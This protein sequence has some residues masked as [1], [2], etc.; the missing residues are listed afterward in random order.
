MPD[1]SRIESSTPKAV[2]SV[3]LRWG[4]V[5]VGNIAGRFAQGLNFVPNTTLTGVWAR[6]ESESARF[7]AQYST[8]AFATFEEMVNSIDA[9]Y[10]ATLQDS[11]ADYAL[12]AFAAKC[13]VL[14][15]KPAA[16]SAKALKKIQDAAIEANVL[17]ME[18]MKPPFFPLFQRLTQQLNDEPIGDIKFVRAGS[19]IPDAPENHP[20]FKLELG[21]GSLL[22]IGI[23]E[24][25]LAIYFLGKPLKVQTLG[26]VGESGV[27]IFASLNV[28][29][30]KGISQ[31]FSGL[32]VDGKGDAVI[33]GTK[34]S[35]TIHENWWNPSRATVHYV[36][37][38]VVELDVPFEG[39]GLNYETDHF[40]ELLRQ[41]A[42]ES[43]IISHALSQQMISILD[44]AREAL[45]VVYPC[46]IDHT[47][48]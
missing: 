26:R 13:A 1:N 25:F 15:E 46:A 20:S 4:I 2:P 31:L 28:L 33:A 3:P 22:N 21:G 40:C 34:G 32:D 39:G 5:G 14:C 27:D 11:H 9:L 36:G 35:V 48:E 44:V 43:P 41:G 19:S 7:A 6:R 42:T 16:V 10:I 45:G 37:G 30:E 38:R 18:A 47:F 24:A 8:Q 23:Y 17:F 12:R 29:H